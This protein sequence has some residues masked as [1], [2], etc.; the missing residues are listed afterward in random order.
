MFKK[1]LKE[2]IK[3]CKLKLNYI[4]MKDLKLF[5]DYFLIIIN[6]N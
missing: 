2:N 1:Y 4:V 3:I 5:C 6:L